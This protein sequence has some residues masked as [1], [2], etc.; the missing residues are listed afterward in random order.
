MTSETGASQISQSLETDL[1]SPPDYYA[2]PA[3][4][5]A[6]TQAVTASFFVL[7]SIVGIALWGLPFFY[8][9][10][11]QQFGWSRAQVTSG[12][13]I[14][15][16]LIGPAFGFIA[17]WVVDHFGPKR[18]MIS[19]ILMAGAALISPAVLLFLLLECAG[20]CLWRAPTM[21]GPAVALVRQIARQG[22]GVCLS[23]N[24]LWRS[25]RTLDFAPAG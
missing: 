22:D 19:G 4:R 18:L 16:L 10:M 11:F 12:N 7:F 21:P 24:R 2:E 13:A 20:L 25:G 23:G 3:Q 1:S 6:A 14:G 8:D 9:F 17:G 15:K 5:R